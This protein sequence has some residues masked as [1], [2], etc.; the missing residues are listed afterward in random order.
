[1]I[2][3]SSLSFGVGV[4][5]AKDSSAEKW[6]CRTLNFKF[7]KAGTYK[8]SFKAKNAEGLEIPF[9]ATI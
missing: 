1:M 5:E 6:A 7:E 2:C 4:Y 9:S 8:M 3:H